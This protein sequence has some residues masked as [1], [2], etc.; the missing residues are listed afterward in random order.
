MSDVY[1]LFT[2]YRFRA[3]PGYALQRVPWPLSVTVE[4]V[5]AEEDR[6]AARVTMRGIHLGEFQGLAP[7][8]KRVEDKAIDMFNVSGGKI[9][10][11]WRDGDDPTD[12]PHP[13]GVPDLPR[14]PLSRHSYSCIETGLAW[15]W[16]RPKAF[17]EA[18]VGLARNPNGSS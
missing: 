5:M 10:E 1:H 16:K 17:S 3:G 8:G 2:T 12:F 4:D 11:H 9:V 7:I 6:V 18:L 13:P 15:A 14:T